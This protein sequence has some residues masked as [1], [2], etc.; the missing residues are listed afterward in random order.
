MTRNKRFTKKEEIAHSIS[1]GAGAVFAI[2]ALVLMAVFSTKYGTVW[3]VVSYVIYGSFL[4][5]L[6]V[7]ST[8]NH[9]LP[10]GSKAKDFFHNFDQIAIFLFIAA[11]YTPIAL[12]VLRNDWGWV[13]FGI[14]WGLALT[15]VMIKIFI[16][17][18]FEKGVNIFYV[19]AYIIMG[20]LLLLFIIPLYHN[21][22]PTGLKLI[23]IGGG[24]Y[25]LGV[26]FFKLEKIKYSH[27]IWHLLVIAG[28]VS[29]WIAIFGYTLNR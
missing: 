15:G 3:H 23:L 21:M 2:V 20:W 24:C 10:L 9:S 14:E 26:L 22:H 18:K 28:S 17:N 29:H 4:V 13:M 25:T 27:L 16:P 5:L 8:L 19:I 6:Y 7:S 11:T 1:H 12:V